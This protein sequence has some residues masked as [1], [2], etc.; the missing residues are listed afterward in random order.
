[1]GWADRSSTATLDPVRLLRVMFVTFSVTS[2]G[3]DPFWFKR[4]KTTV[5]SEATGELR[6]TDRHKPSDYNKNWTFIDSVP[7]L[8]H[9]NISAA[10]FTKQAVK[11]Y[12]SSA[13]R[14]KRV[15]SRRL[16]HRFTAASFTM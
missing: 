14:V 16:C 12:S 5:H 10:D 7:V 11:F 9:V 13:A 1:M 4:P 3:L 15:I 2:K 6:E 8:E